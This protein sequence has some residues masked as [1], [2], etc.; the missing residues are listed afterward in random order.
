MKLSAAQEGALRA[1]VDRYDRMVQSE[2]SRWG[3]ESASI[4]AGKGVEIADVDYR[5]LHAL[6]NRGL[7]RLRYGEAGGE[8][9]RRGAFGRWIGGTRK[10]TDTIFFA[11]PTDL[12]R[13]VAWP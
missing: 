1:V 2:R 3:E 7:V 12:G 5:T 10:Y 11:T 8:S 13:K 4:V 6:E 9:L